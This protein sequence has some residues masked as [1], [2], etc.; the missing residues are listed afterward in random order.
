MALQSY[1][2]LNDYEMLYF[3]Q[4]FLIQKLFQK[5]FF[6]TEN[7]SGSTKFYVFTFVDYKLL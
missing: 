6:S 3:M 4:R 5:C 1:K 2:I 7:G